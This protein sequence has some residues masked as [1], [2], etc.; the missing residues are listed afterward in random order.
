MHGYPVHFLYDKCTIQ[1]H[2][3]VDI[4]GIAG[5]LFNNLYKLDMYQ[6]FDDKNTLAVDSQAQRNSEPWHT[7]FC[8]LNFSSLARLSKHD[9][10]CNLPSIHIPSNHVCEGCMKDT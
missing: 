9:M 10:V 2:T 1:D 3:K 8:H 7:R 6:K 4:I 5:S